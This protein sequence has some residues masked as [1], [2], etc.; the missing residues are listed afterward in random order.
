MR[1]SNLE[2]IRHLQTE[3]L[4]LR[5][6]VAR[7]QSSENRDAD[8]LRNLRGKNILLWR[9]QSLRRTAENERL[10]LS[11]Q[12][13]ERETART[14]APRED[15]QN[16]MNKQLELRCRR[17]ASHRC[18]IWR[19]YSIGHFTH[20]W[21]HISVCSTKFFRRELS[22]CINTRFFSSD[23]RRKPC[24]KKKNKHNRRAG[25]VPSVLSVGENFAQDNR[26]NI[27]ATPC[28]PATGEPRSITSVGGDLVQISQ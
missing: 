12:E 15:A 27:H 7:N 1:T 13:A 3:L 24:A 23:G 25:E 19:T 22:F 26:A 16:T 18:R 8:N 14:Q 10:T 5:N 20:R 2:Q 9:R 4:D 11:L 17:N 28:I 21:R 6:S